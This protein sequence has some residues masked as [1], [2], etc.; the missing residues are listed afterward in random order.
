MCVVRP[1]L[2]FLATLTGWLLVA[3]G[4]ALAET[5]LVKNKTPLPV[6]VQGTTV[7]RGQLVRDRAHLVQPG[8]VTPPIILPGNKVLTV[9]DARNANRILVQVP[10]QASM[11]DI[12]LE[13]VPDTTSP[14]G[15]RLD[16]VRR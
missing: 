15:L 12:A 4:P 2:W 11:D 9:F 16:R 7:I 5:I 3:A 14:S 8:D 13:V 10:I 6:V 1:A